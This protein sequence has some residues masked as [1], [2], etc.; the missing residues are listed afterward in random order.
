MW[1]KLL[2]F[3]RKSGILRGHVLAFKLDTLKDVDF[4]Y[5]PS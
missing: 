1:L 4:L 5:V 3:C 2:C